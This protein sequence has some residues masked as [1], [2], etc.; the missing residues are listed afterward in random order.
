MGI[1]YLQ[2]A[3]IGGLNAEWGMLQ[4]PVNDAAML[5]GGGALEALSGTRFLACFPN[6]HYYFSNAGGLW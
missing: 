3:D 5:L 6:S 2:D 1:C 4:R